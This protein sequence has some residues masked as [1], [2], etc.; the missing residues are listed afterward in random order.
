MR[1][2]LIDQIGTISCTGQGHVV[3]AITAAC[4]LG[5][6]DSKGILDRVNSFDNAFAQSV[7]SELAVFDEHVVADRVETIDRWIDQNPVPDVA[8]RVLDQRLRNRSLEALSLGVVLFNLPK[9]RIVQI[10]NAYGGLQHTDRSRIRVDGVPKQ[11]I[12]GYR[13][14]DSWTIVP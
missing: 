1:F 10:E 6:T 3:K 11:Q 7:R 5:A 2:T 14:P 8:F 12:Y 4:S 9:R 13:L